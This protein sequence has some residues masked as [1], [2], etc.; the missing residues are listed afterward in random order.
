MPGQFIAIVDG[1][2]I[3]ARPPDLFHFRAASSAHNFW[4]SVIAT[5]QGLEIQ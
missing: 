1:D 2:S 3:A 4:S 5:P